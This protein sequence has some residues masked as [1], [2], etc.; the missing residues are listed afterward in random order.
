MTCSLVRP[1][2]PSPGVF[3]GLL[4]PTIPTCSWF[5]GFDVADV[6]VVVGAIAVAVGV[7]VLVVVVV[8][9]GYPLK[10]WRLPL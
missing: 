5:A 8:V 10:V 6:V 1:V 7:V 9:V 3:G 4:G 2:I